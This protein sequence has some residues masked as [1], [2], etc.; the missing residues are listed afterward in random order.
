MASDTVI[1]DKQM[2]PLIEYPCERELTTPTLA[3]VYVQ[4]KWLYVKLETVAAGNCII[5]PRFGH[6][7]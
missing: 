3:D 7:S 1:L 5:L 4:A 2:M 6:S